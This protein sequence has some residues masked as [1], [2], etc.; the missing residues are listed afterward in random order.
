MKVCIVS[1]A[2]GHLTEV[3]ALRRAYERWE[4]FYVL[5]DEVQLPPDMLS[6]TLTIPHVERSWKLLLSVVA[7]WRILKRER[8][9][10]I[11]STGAGPVVP[12]ALLGRACFGCRVVF[13]ETV[14]RLHRPSLTGRLMYHLAHDFY[15]Q[16]PTLARYFPRGRCVGNLL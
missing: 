12:F 8:P 10:V 13:V 6:R 4:Y 11:L 16:W 3:R 7:A 2:G 5:N 1:S 15:Y 9:D 14:T